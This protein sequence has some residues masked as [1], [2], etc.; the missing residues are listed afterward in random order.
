M[1]RW[2]IPAVVG[3]CL[4]TAI[5]AALFWWGTRERA[6]RSAELERETRLA[7]I[8]LT[9]RLRGGLDKHRIALEQF[10]SFIEN[11]EDVSDQEFDRFASK[12]LTLTPLCLRIPQVD[13]SYHVSRVF[14]RSWQDSM[15]GFDVHTHP[16]GFETNLRARSTRRTALSVPLDLVG[17]TP[18]FILAAPMFHGK[19]FL[20]NLISLVPDGYLLR[21]DGGSADHG[22]LRGRDP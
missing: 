15:L 12:T 19:D 5:I 6:E 17:G 22:A 4:T 9:A 3:L 8:Q 16:T 10:A 2:G 21:V 11:D 18:G 20:G 14:P 1:R 13:P 7:A